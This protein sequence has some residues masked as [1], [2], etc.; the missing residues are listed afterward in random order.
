MFFFV[1]A[2]ARRRFRPVGV[3]SP[4]QAWSLKGFKN[5]NLCRCSILIKQGET[6]NVASHDQS[7]PWPPGCQHSLSGT[8][9]IDSSILQH[10]RCD[11]V[12]TLAKGVRLDGISMQEQ[13]RSI[14]WRLSISGI[15]GSS[16]GDFCE[17]F[18]VFSWLIPQGVKTSTSCTFCRGASQEG[19]GGGGLFR[20]WSYFLISSFHFWQNEI[21]P[22]YLTELL[23]PLSS[24][25]GC[26]FWKNLYPADLPAVISHPHSRVSFH[27]LFSHGTFC[28]QISKSV[29]HFSS[30]L[31][32]AYLKV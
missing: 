1:K 25:C 26:I 4:G 9:R 24:L 19:G 12:A 6:K 21:H 2:K 20:R 7:H 29:H 3:I 13:C 32:R 17:I 10:T 8:I 22:S 27:T 16:A 18:A 30:F 15:S 28:H 14:C 31:F 23:P 5:F 11:I